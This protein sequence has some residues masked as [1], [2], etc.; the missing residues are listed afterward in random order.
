MKIDTH[1]HYWQYRPEA[2]PW[3][4]DGMPALQRDCMPA[5]CED[6]LREAGV[7]GV[8]AV[9]ARC[10]AQETDFLLQLAQQHPHVLGVVG[11]ANLLSPR[12]ESQLDTW[13]TDT[14]LKGFRHILQDEPDVAAWVAAP[15]V[16]TGLAALQKR[17]LVYDVL[18]FDHQLPLVIDLCARHSAHWL[19]L[20]HA[21]KPPLRD[22]AR[23]S[24]V[25]VQWRHNMSRLARL[26]HVMCKLSGLVTETQWSSGQGLAPADEVNI[27]G[28]FDYA[29]SVF[30]PDR[31]MFG[32][33]WPVCQIAA[34]YGAVHQ[35][36][37]TWAKATLTLAQQSAFWSGNAIRC[38]GLSPS[39]TAD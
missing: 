21:G 31:L 18:V 22:W 2:F 5:D 10:V 1:Q 39:L 20:D 14:T 4:T 32:S 24:E 29:L 3:I 27:G 36:A 15:E 8:V 37:Q 13:C 17:G 19:V 38:Y 23:D 35:L 33:D 34:A 9:Q 7:Q 12:L 16:H 11:W 25:A 6:A 30:G 26:P 28:C